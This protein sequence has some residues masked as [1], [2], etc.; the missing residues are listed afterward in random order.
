MFPSGIVVFGLKLSLYKPARQVLQ[1]TTSK[2]VSSPV[3]VLVF[4]LFL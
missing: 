4:I 1:T 2:P 3:F